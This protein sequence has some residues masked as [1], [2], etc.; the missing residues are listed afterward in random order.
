MC[1]EFIDFP[2]DRDPDE[3]KEATIPQLL[4]LGRA[5]MYAYPSVLI[6]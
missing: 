4:F 2:A 5:A 6:L 1:I 3:D